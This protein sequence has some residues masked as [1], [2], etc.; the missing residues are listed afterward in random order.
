MAFIFGSFT[1]LFPF[2]EVQQT[3]VYFL[4]TITYSNGTLTQ[5]LI[6]DRYSAFS[7]L[8]L[9]TIRIL[10]APDTIDTILVNGEPHVDFHILPSKEIHVYNLKV[11][12]NSRYTITFTESDSNSGNSL[13]GYSCTL[14]IISFL[15]NLLPLLQ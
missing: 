13:F 8:N 1:Y 5:S 3:G 11:P 10:G 12:V 7:Q 2:T 9:E 14:L 4:S 6:Q 15:Y